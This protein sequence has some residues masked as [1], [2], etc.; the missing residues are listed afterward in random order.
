MCC[1]ARR[2]SINHLTSGVCQEID[3]ARSDYFSWVWADC[4]PSG[5]IMKIDLL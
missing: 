3:P 5:R 4:D 2:V 1:A